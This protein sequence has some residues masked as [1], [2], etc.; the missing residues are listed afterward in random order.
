MFL[1]E[2]LIPYFYHLKSWLFWPY[3]RKK[4]NYIMHVS[5]DKNQ[6][7]LNQHNDMADTSLTKQYC[8][9]IISYANRSL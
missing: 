7:R 3:I 9:F 1:G 6:T 5:L 8:L 4:Q 2:Q